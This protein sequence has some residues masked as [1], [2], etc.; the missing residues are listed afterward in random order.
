M[1]NSLENGH[2]LNQPMVFEE[3]TYQQR[4]L[5]QS[6]QVTKHILQIISL[7]SYFCM[8]SYCDVYVCVCVC[9]CVHVRV[10]VRERGRE[11]EQVSEDRREAC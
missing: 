4:L 6:N 10:C 5:S 1:K 11:R 3:K 9:V 7:N 2:P 8:L